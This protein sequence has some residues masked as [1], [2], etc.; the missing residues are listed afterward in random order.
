MIRD[1]TTGLR[2]TPMAPPKAKTEEP[3]VVNTGE[4]PVNLSGGVLRVGSS[5]ALAGV[6]SKWTV[7][8]PRPEARRAAW[9]KATPACTCPGGQRA[10][11]LRMER[12]EQ[13]WAVLVGPPM[14][15]AAHLARDWVHFLTLCGLSRMRVPPFVQLLCGVWARVLLALG[16][17]NMLS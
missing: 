9:L 16:G 14:G 2:V 4:L 17:A 5:A 11:H 6:P 13:L 1:G 8:T 10:R 7:F 12:G 15:A 3:A